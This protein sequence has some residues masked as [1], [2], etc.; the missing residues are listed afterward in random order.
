MCSWQL[1]EYVIMLGLRQKNQ[2]RNRVFGTNSDF[3]EFSEF[4]FE[5]YLMLFSVINKKAT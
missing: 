3:L 1:Y 5:N 2:Q 4:R